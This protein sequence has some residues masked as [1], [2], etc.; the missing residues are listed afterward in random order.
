MTKQ[1]PISPRRSRARWLPQETSLLKYF[2]L[3]P[4]VI[5]D[6]ILFL[7]PLLFLVWIGFWSVENYRAVPGFSLSN[8]LD[9]FSQFF[10]R[11]RYGYAIAQSLWVAFTTAALG[12]LLC[13]P[14]AM[15]LV[16]LVPE[17]LQRLLLVLAI[18]PF[19]T[20][21]ILRLYAWQTILN[22]NG[23][24][25]S[26]LVQLHWIKEPLQIMFT[27]W[28]TRI[29]LLHYL[30]PIMILIL[31]LVLR[32]VDRTLMGAARNLGATQWQTFWRVVLPL[33]KPG[34]VYSAVFGLIISLGDVLS[35][36]IL[37]GG[38]GQSIL[39]KFPLFSTIILNEYAASTNLPRTSAL[40]TLLI[41]IMIVILV[42]GFK[43]AESEQ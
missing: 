16:F 22:N 20:S 40:A 11:S 23:L 19:W 31:Y 37:G 2:C 5:Y 17:R 25:N 18:T 24:L 32:N 34:I 29:G 12:I 15:A 28:G 6:S 3:A 27:Q 9:I 14:F 39:G 42:T 35:G 8:Y 30:A 38:T 10:A 21:Y 4:A 41:G 26:L 36:T 33:S 1:L 7:M 13:Y 43:L